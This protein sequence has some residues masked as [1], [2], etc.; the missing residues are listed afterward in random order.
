MACGGSATIAACVG[1][2]R[3]RGGWPATAARLLSA[4]SS[5]VVDMGDVTFVD[6]SGLRVILQVANARNGA[7]PLTLVNASRVARL[8]K[9]VG[10]EGIRSIDVRGGDERLAG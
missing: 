9:L 1:E 2:T 4:D 8:L 5:A 6:A 7:G 3:E 10:L